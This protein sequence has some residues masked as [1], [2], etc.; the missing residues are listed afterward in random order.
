MSSQRSA[1]DATVAALVGMGFA[2]ALAN[3]PLFWLM[4]VATLIG[5]AIVYAVIRAGS[6]RHARAPRTQSAQTAHGVRV[7]VLFAI[8]F[9]ITRVTPSAEWRMA[10]AAVGGLI[11][12][13]GGYVVLR[14]EAIEATRE[15]DA[16]A[17]G[18]EDVRR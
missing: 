4:A 15:Q 10:Y 2:M 3:T 18:D 5:A 1:P 17:A 14:L 16:N 8:A 13:V 12:G 6:R 11:V 9:L 7:L